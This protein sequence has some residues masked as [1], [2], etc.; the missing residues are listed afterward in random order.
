MYSAWRFVSWA[1]RLKI[2]GSVARSACI[3]DIRIPRKLELRLQG[4][5]PLG[6]DSLQDRA[7][8]LEAAPHTERVVAPRQG[9]YLL[10]ERRVLASFF[11][12]QVARGHEQLDLGRGADPETPAKVGV[13]QDV[14]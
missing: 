12:A 9:R 2:S 6:A 8:T 11:V 3:S 10:G 14:P 5:W 4:G 7:A 1:I 13:R